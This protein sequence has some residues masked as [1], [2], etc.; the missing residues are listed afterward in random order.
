MTIKDN[1]IEL[2]KVDHAKEADVLFELEK[3]A[4]SRDFDLTSRNTQELIDYLKGSEVYALYEGQDTVGF[5]A[6]RQGK[7]DVELLVIAVDP[8]KQ[9]NGYGKVMMNKIL[10]LTMKQS[11]RLMTHPKNSTAI[12]FYLKSGFTISGW[13]DNY[14]GDEQPR[15]LLTYNP[16]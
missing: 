14:Y 16:Q 11:V 15:L 5:F 2:K 8:K 1:N 13:K 9:R 4:F 10:E 12:C 3:K 7:T 6:F